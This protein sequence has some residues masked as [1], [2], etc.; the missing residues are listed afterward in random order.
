MINEHSG[1]TSLC[2]HISVTILLQI[3]LHALNRKND[4]KVTRQDLVWALSDSNI[5]LEKIPFE[6]V[7]KY[8]GG[9]LGAD[10]EIEIQL[11]VRQLSM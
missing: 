2:N 6:A 10:A 5:V 9:G 4:G 7:W 8:L 11:I 1:C 3:S